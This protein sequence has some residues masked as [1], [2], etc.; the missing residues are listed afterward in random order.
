MK[1]DVTETEAFVYSSVLATV[2]VL[3][4]YI[5][6]PLYDPPYDKKRKHLSSK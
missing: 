2:F 6:K 5:W 3:A 1:L 4:V